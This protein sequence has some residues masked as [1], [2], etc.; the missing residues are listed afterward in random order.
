MMWVPFALGAAFFW[1]MANIADRII[2]EKYITNSVLTVVIL[3][4]FEMAVTIPLIPAANLEAFT[5][6]III[7]ILSSAAIGLVATVFYFQSIVA[8]EISRVIP[9]FQFVPVFTLLFA[10]LLFGEQLTEKQGISFAIIFVGVLF[11][12]IERT[13]QLRIR[14]SRAFW[15]ALVSS[16]FFA[17]SNVILA[18]ARVLLPD[19]LT[20]FVGTQ[21]ANFILILF[22]LMLAPAHLRL[23]LQEFRMIGASKTRWYALSVGGSLIGYALFIAALPFAPIALVSVLNGIQ[24]FFVFLFAMLLTLF[25]PAVMHEELGA[26]TII[27]KVIAILIVFTGTYLLFV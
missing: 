2:H 13:S 23:V 8:H 1:A 7:L 19:T 20:T 10:A 4:I 27:I 24:P 11:L 26:R 25:A 17:I 21:I 15:L 3:S 22:Y 12:S 18:Q 9:T 5:P 14:L 16:G 6:A